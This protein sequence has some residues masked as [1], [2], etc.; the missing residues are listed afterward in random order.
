MI[1]S[2]SFHVDEA[3]TSTL[4]TPIKLKMRQKSAQKQEK[5]LLLQNFISR[6]QLLTPVWLCVSVIFVQIMIHSHSF[7]VD[8]TDNRTLMTP[9]YLKN[10]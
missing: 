1:H 8:E 3:N 6:G 4:K 2:H 9:I 10:A 7:H 5:S